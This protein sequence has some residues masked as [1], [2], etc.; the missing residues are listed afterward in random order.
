MK[1]KK[2]LVIYHLMPMKNYWAL[3][4]EGAKNAARI[5]KYPV[6]WSVFSSCMSY[7]EDMNALYIHGTD[8]KVITKLD[9]AFINLFYDW[10]Q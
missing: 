1:K 10:G 3:K 5:S 6:F 7:G 8:G 2:E 9:R 4:K